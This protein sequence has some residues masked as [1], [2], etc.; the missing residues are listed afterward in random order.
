MGASTSGRYSVR[1]AAR[2]ALSGTLLIALNACRE[3][4]S[5]MHDA[6]SAAS[7]NDGGGHAGPAAPQRDADPDADAVALDAGA[8][9]TDAGDAGSDARVDPMRGIWLASSWGLALEA[10]DGVLVMHEITEISCRPYLEV[11]YEGLT[12]PDLGMT[13][14][15]EAGN[16]VLRGGLTDEMIA[17]PIATLPSTCA[18]GGT[19][20]TEDPVLA[21]E[22][23]WRNFYELYS[24]FDI[25]NIDW[26]SQYDAF[27]G[28]VT[29]ETTTDELFA[30]LCDM[31]RQ[32]DD[33]HVSLTL[34]EAECAS[35][36]APAWL[37][38][39][40]ADQVLAAVDTYIYE[41]ASKTANDLIP[42]RVLPEN[43]GYVFI[44]GMGGYADTPEAD[45][46]TA[47]EAADEIVAA[48]ANVDGVIIDVR[49]NGGGDD[50]IGMAIANRFADQRR[51]A[52][53]VQTRAG[54]GWTETRDY[55]VEPEGP[56]QFT[57]PVVLL[58]S[59]FTVS[60]AEVFALA[61]GVLPR[62]TLI[63]ETT[64]GALSTMTYRNLPDGIGFTLPFE[65]TFADD[66][67][68]YEGVGITPD[69][70]LPFDA[71]AFIDGDD[72]MLEYAVQHL[73]NGA[74][75]SPSAP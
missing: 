16:L 57:G 39:A 61:L 72:K 62:V 46:Q 4:N 38:G 31:T 70:E 65:R 32:F 5:P 59:T 23:F 24:S 60:A 37:E 33:P 2:R 74:Q 17:T 75:T 13:G 47:R 15:I 20:T 36:A 19:P 28:R 14:E 21:F 68:C 27:V 44:S 35:H 58:T 50:G 22:I 71:D 69:I 51:H 67:R 18:N 8:K 64:A 48:F 9:P 11:P 43:I 29:S 40:K 54:D 52:F 10:A 66:G 55:Y 30:L 73:L 25:R 45:L 63:G 7:T 1:A 53:S 49:M 41:D 6:L 26:A 3:G 12:I 56:A 34:G 42:Y